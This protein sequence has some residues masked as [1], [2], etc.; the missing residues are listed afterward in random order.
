M[1]QDKLKV[2]LVDD[3]ENTRNL[4]R[5]VL[6]W[7][8]MGFEIAGEASSG[9]EGL[10][11]VDELLPDLIV[12]D[13]K[14]PFMDGLEFARLVAENYPTIKVIVLTAY[15]E[16]EYAKQGIKMG[17]SDFLLKPIKRSE[18]KESIENIRKK[19][20]NERIDREEYNKVREKLKE[21]LPI[22][23]EKL[24]NDLVMS[25]NL[26]QD[27]NEKL[28]YY[29]LSILKKYFQIAV[30]SV[31]EVPSIKD[32][33]NTIVHQILYIDIIKQYF[34]ADKNI[35]VFDNNR[36]NTVI[37]NS[38]KQVNLP[39]CCEQIKTMI[40][41]KLKCDISI[42]L[43]NIYTQLDKLHQGYKEA[44]E[45]LNYKAIYGSNIVI[46]YRD[47]CI[48]RQKP[49]SINIV[50]I[51]MEEV[52]FYIRA[53]IADKAKELLRERFFRIRDISL[54]SS[55]ELRVMGIS[56]ITAVL[57]SISE[58]DLNLNE[59]FGSVSSLY[60]D[61]LEFNNVSEIEAYIIDV[62][63]KLTKAIN[64][65]REKKKKSIMDN[66]I[67]YLK[68]NI[69]NSELTL[70]ALASH[71]FINPSYL[72]RTFKQHTGY[73]FVEYLTRLRIQ[74]AIELFNSCDAMAYEV[75]EKVGIPDPNY[76]GKCFKKYTGFSIND[77]KK[78][79]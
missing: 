25:N 44:L 32:Q 3:E 50:D 51:G 16:F 15:E 41:N 58:M 76:F 78:Q 21:S 8:A 17:I 70:T 60:S 40:I 28:E 61:V 47:I 20:L 71:F 4:L 75:A 35:I 5:L 29:N 49:S 65:L 2:M 59:I 69:S 37:I 1:R 19:I 10:N 73:T 27:I 67:S 56:M 46:Q 34:K 23:I 26:P 18:I 9:Q 63:E 77:Y 52:T 55:N 62:T 43:S 79:R 66:I 12:T 11:L 72:S 45:A 48:D 39:E 57:D 31:G 74:K 6:D 14:M 36:G 30:V 53:G 22:L 13:I 54:S 68:D 24:L 33:E 38:D 7:E 42:G 64:L